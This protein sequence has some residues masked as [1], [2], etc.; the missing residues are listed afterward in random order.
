[1]NHDGGLKVGCGMGD[2][3]WER[4]RGLEENWGGLWTCGVCVCTQN[5]NKEEDYVSLF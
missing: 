3:G 2:E 5:E 4:E 1:M